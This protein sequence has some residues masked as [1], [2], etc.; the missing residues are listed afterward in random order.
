MVFSLC[1]RLLL[2]EGSC[3]SCRPRFS[4]WAPGVGC[5]QSRRATLPYAVA[6]LAGNCTACGARRA[7][8]DTDMKDSNPVKRRTCS[9]LRTPSN[10]VFTTTSACGP[11]CVYASSGAITPA[12][13]STKIGCWPSIGA[14][15]RDSW[16][17]AAARH[18]PAPVLDDSRQGLRPLPCSAFRRQRASAVADY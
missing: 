8:V 1:V 3:C 15:L 16:Q 14:G 12:T 17:R 10:T 9:P 2:Y 6:H 18:L 13:E 7:R 5:F 11:S 4:T